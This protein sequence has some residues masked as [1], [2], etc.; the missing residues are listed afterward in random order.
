MSPLVFLKRPER[1]LWTIHYHRA[2]LSGGPNFAYELC[3]RNIDERMIE[4]LDLDCWRVAANGAEPIYP[5][6]I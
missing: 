4:G 5:G 1:W 3:V 6:T 2:T